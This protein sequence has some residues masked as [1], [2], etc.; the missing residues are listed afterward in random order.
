MHKKI[1][2]IT[3]FILLLGS[4][5]W[6][7]T[8]NSRVTTPTP[9]PTSTSQISVIA[10]F[11]PLAFFAQQ[12]GGNLVHVQTLVTPGLEPHDFEP[13]PQNLVEI[14]KASLLIYNGAGL[15][16]WA[17]RIIP[18]LPPEKV[19]NATTGITLLPNDPHVWMDPHLALQQVENIKNG[20]IKVD[21]A[22]QTEY[23]KNALQLENQL[24]ELDQQFQAGL[25]HCQQHDI[26]TSHDAFEYLARE[27]NLSVLP[28]AGLSPDE[29]PTPKKLA[30]VSQFV[31]KNQVKYIFFETLVSPKLS[32]TIA[33]ETGTQTAAF[34]PLEGLTEAEMNQGQN[35]FTVQQQNLKNLQQTLACN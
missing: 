5:V 28:I 10:S 21:P 24:N 16:A 29:E 22:H 4:G 32:Q 20:L 6:L 12:I 26:V 7:I 35:Y 30:E 23:Q 18:N 33:Q 8:K 9:S 31:K 17:P 11:Y 19:V 27:Y 14:E 2:L 34:N 25:A 1:L 15:E 13:T 3:L